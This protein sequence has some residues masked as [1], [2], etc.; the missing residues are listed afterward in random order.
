MDYGTVQQRRTDFGAG[1]VQLHKG[2]GVTDAK[3]GVGLWCQNRP[4]WQITGV[5]VFSMMRLPLFPQKNGRT[6]LTDHARVDLACLSQSLYSLSIYDTLGPDAA[7]FIINDAKLVCV[8]TSLTHIPSLLRMKARCPTLKL[9]VSLDPIDYSGISP[10]HSVA[11]ILN[12]WAAD[13]GVQLHEMGTIEALG[14]SFP[15]PMV[16]PQPSDI[17][18]INYTSGTTGNPK[19]VV[20]VHE[21]AVAAASNGKVLA[22][23]GPDDVVC[24]YLPL[25][26]IYER[27]IEHIVM[28]SG[29]RI[30]YFHGN[31]LELLDDLRLLR[32]TLFVSVPRLYNRFG[33]GLRAATVEQ[34][35][36]KGLLSR[37]VVATKLANLEAHGTT[38]HALWDRVWSRKAAA[39][40]G[41]ERAHRMISGAAPL[42]ARLHQFLRVVFS[43]T[44]VQGYGMTESYAVGLNQL[45]GDSSAGNCGAVATCVEAC[46]LDVPDMGYRHTDRPC[47][48][49]ELLLRGPAVFR[50]Y[51]GNAAETRRTLL[52]LPS[53]SS[54]SSSGGGSGSSS[55]GP[56]LRTGDICAV[57]AH[58]RFTVV[59][60][61]KNL[62]KLAQGEYVSPERIE[63]VFLANCSWLAQAFVHGDGTRGHLV[64][65]FGFSPATFGA[66]VQRA[67]RQQ[68]VAGGISVAPAFA[69]AAAT[70]SAAAGGER[71]NSDDGRPASGHAAPRH[72]DRGRLSLAA[73]AAGAAGGAAG[74]GG[75]I[76]GVG[77]DDTSLDASS[78]SSSSPS[79]SS[80]TSSSSS[81][82]PSPATASPPASSARLGADAD[83]GGLLAAAQDVRVRRAV[84]RELDRVSRANRFNGWERVRNCYLYLEPFTVENDLLTPT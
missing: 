35:G 1:L 54:L 80:S 58:G 29:G 61:V 16:P 15:H 52:E 64:A 74:A 25:A 36:L 78:S 56:W 22:P 39:A 26:H 31:I 10:G 13:A 21:N 34:P 41:L 48:R 38:T 18:T 49:G 28:W 47:A 60:R 71:D 24:S 42:D 33:S 77:A 69:P 23:T 62:L 6:F 66:F 17:V 81:P 7:E 72:S 68:P 44:F 59:D 70:T 57:D 67:L 65:I 3:Y 9:I 84:L 76:A 45:P 30:G 8:V 73:N 5:C 55:K 4:E 20:L 19:G 2:V 53:S 37:H 50:G 32:P 40:F 83:A 11:S 43:N 75:G 82:S 51:F 79:T 27:L 14:R 12:G 46:L 63:N